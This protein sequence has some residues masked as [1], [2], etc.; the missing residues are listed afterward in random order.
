MQREGIAGWQEISSRIEGKVCAAI[1]E[2]EIFPAKGLF[3]CPAGKALRDG[4]KYHQGSK[5]RHV[6]RSD[7]LR[8]FRP[9]GL[10]VCRP[11]MNMK[12][13]SLKWGPSQ[14]F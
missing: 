8:C 7:N 12:T 10:L 5:G 1:R 11:G 3:S 6:L 2:L 14:E 13:Y 4:G 9:K